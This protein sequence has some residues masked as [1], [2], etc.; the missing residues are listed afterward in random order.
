[1][2]TTITGG[3]IRDNSVDEDDIDEDSI[4]ASEISSEAIT[5][6]GAYSGDVDTVN[7]KILIYDDSASSLKKV[8]P[9]EIYQTTSPSIRVS[10]G[11]STAE[12]RWIKIARTSVAGD[13]W[14][15]N[16]TTLL[17]TITASEY[18]DAESFD[19]SFLIQAKFSAKDSSPYYYSFGTQI[20]CEPINADDISGFDPTSDLAITLQDQDANLMEIWIKA[21]TQYKEVFAAHVG[22]TNLLDFYAVDP[23]AVIQT[24]QSWSTSLTSLGTEIYGTWASKVTSGLTVIGDDPRIKIDGITDSHPGLEFYENGTRKWI[25]F[26]NYGD[27]SLDFKTNSDTR[28]VINQDGTVG[29][30]T[31]SPAT[32]L[33]INGALTLSEKSSD[34]SNPSEGQ[35]VL[36]MS[37][38]TGTGDDGDIL[39]KITAGGT[40]KTVTLVDFSAS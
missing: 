17:V 31:Q 13:G 23:S 8:S 26:N 22:G 37:D 35:S 34:P 27:D 19:G 18:R 25:I 6:Q 9:G 5:G 32:E 40:T 39:M 20:T 7:D 36:W 4:R 30:G 3:Q 11:Q 1:M 28:M 2:R 10:N 12:N 38:G 14:Q 24:S 16:V 33:H 21:P 15:T 29:I